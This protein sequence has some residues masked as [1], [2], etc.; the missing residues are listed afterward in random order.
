MR[1]VDGR[2]NWRACRQ[3]LAVTALAVLRQRLAYPTRID[4]ARSWG[5]TGGPEGETVKY[6]DTPGDRSG[7]SRADRGSSVWARNCGTDEFPLP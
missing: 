4:G 6:D 5:G 3:S 1:T 2:H 7:V